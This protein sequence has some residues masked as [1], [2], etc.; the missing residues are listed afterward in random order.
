[1][2]NAFTRWI[3]GALFAALGLLIAIGP[4]TIFKPCAGLLELLP[5]NRFVPMKCHWSGIAEIGI[6]GVI[7]ILGLLLLFFSQAQI[8]FGM[9]LAQA[10]LGITAVLIPTRLI[11][12]CA[13]PT[14][15]CNIL[16][17]PMLLAAGCLVI[18]VSAVNVLL[19]KKGVW[20]KEK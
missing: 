17:R 7:A 9:S 16:M 18:T 6:G 1:M 10:A 2:K 13:A 15:R 19:L 8:R 11:G 12:T 5:G 14:M 20:G 3:S 4:Q